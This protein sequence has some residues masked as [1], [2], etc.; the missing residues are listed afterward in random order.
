MNRNRR[1]LATINRYKRAKAAAVK[2]ARRRQLRQMIIPFVTMHT[3]ASRRIA[4][5][6]ATARMKAYWA[7]RRNIGRVYRG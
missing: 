3:R 6:N 1:S 7:R 2:V 5:R 4:K